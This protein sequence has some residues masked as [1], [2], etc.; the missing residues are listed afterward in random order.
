MDNNIELEPEEK[1]IDFRKGL[2]FFLITGLLSAISGYLNGKYVMSNSDYFLL[3][4]PQLTEEQIAQIQ[5]PLWLCC[6]A[7][8]F[9]QLFY[10]FL[11]SFVVYIGYYLTIKQK[12]GTILKCVALSQI[13]FGVMSI[14]NVLKIIIYGLPECTI[15]LSVY[16][17]SLASFFDVCRLDMWM[18]IPLSYFNIFEIFFVLLLSYLLSKNFN[19]SFS[20]SLKM[21]LYT[22]GLTLVLIIICLCSSYIFMTE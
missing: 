6:I 19:N 7:P 15:G 2:L 10:L 21:V 11:L 12:F 22:Y 20:K 17:F 14:V 18:V 4:L 3:L 9:T 16:S 1:N 8:I 5:Q 13:V